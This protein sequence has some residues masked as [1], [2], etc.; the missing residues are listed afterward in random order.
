M[1]LV[2]S[3]PTK[4][5]SK[6][7]MVRASFPGFSL[8]WTIGAIGGLPSRSDVMT[9]A[10]HFNAG[11]NPQRFPSPGGTTDVFKMKSCAKCG[12]DLPSGQPS[13]RDS[14]RCRR[15]PGVE[16]PGYCRVV[17]LGRT[18][19]DGS[20][21]PQFAIRNSKWSGLLF[22]FSVWDGR[23]GHLAVVAVAVRLGDNSP[24]IY[25]WVMRPSNIKVPRGTAENGGRAQAPFVPDGTLEI[26]E[27]RVPAMNGW[28]IFEGAR[29][30]RALRNS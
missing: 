27:P 11:F 17:P 14:C 5:N 21:S 2:T 9:I 20:R 25:G 23:L 19:A 3:T 13:R 18:R 12:N 4:R 7:E 28:A 10:R 8:G 22:R 16:T 1:S 30:G 6:F 29:I 24:A 15:I 26:C